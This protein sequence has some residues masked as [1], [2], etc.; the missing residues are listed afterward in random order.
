MDAERGEIH[1]QVMGE[2]E[3]EILRE[4]IARRFAMQVTFDS[5]T[6]LY[7]E[8][9]AAPVLGIGH[10]EPLRHYAEVQLLLEPL[11]RGSGL[12]FDSLVSEDA[13]D[14]NWQRLI[15][16][17][18]AEKPHRGVLTGA[19]ITDLRISIAAGKAHLKHTEGGD[20]RRRPIAPSGRGCARRR[21]CC[22]SLWCGFA[23]SFRRKIP[24]G[25]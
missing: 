3:L 15:L 8:T 4:L 6:I 24:E 9:I 7:K 10:Y 1:V 12:V 18:L 16:T 20:F 14:R 19:E 13:L 11:P 5:G 25:R 23:W 21:V 2:L 22:W 17:H